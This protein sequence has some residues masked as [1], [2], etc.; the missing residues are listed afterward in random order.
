[1][2]SNREEALRQQEHTSKET[3]NPVQVAS[4]DPISNPAMGRGYNGGAVSCT[5]V[6][7]S[8]TD[9]KSS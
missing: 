1:M 9:E 2:D 7:I 4:L 3:G 8:W 5:F 6:A